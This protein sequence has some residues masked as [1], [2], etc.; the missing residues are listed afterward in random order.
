MDWSGW[1][2]W[3]SGY[4][5]WLFAAGPVVAIAQLACLV[6]AYKTGRPYWWLWIILGFPGLGVVAYVLLEARPSFGRLDYQALLW[7]LKS[8]RQRIAILTRQLEESTTIKNRLVLADALHEDG[9][10]DRECIVLADGL[11][12]PFKDDAPLRLRLVAAQLDAGRTAEAAHLLAG[13]TPDRFGDEP[14][15]HA[16]LGARVLGAQGEIALATAQ[17]QALIAQ[18]KNEGPRYYYAELLAK[19]GRGGEAVAI[20]KDIL[21][22]YRRGTIVWRHVER[23]WFHAA[24]RLLK[25][26]R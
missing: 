26:V 7:R 15:R 23:P 13:T 25:T 17:F 22:Q 6:H 5:G 8:P 21:A 3:L 11:V 9:Q 2:T 1:T 12:G 24:R 19:Q 4:H 16:L 14:F 10:F 20:L 18:R